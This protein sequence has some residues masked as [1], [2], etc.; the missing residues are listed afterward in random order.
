MDEP[1]KK[2]ITTKRPM[3]RPD[4]L[5][6]EIQAKVVMYLKRGNY[7][8]TAAALAGVSRNAIKEW[9]RRGNDPHA[10]KKYRDFLGAVDAA[11]AE[12]EDRDIGRIDQAAAGWREARD[13]KGNL[14]M[15][16]RAPNW[17]AAA[18]RLE[19][20]HPR[21]WANKERLELTGADGGPIKVDEKALDQKIERFAGLLGFVKKTEEG[22]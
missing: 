17:K 3:G 2:A 12:A 21:R 20:R 19:R 6:P 22:K 14:I 18:W 7:V 15:P 1:K 5:T 9:I 10:P 16:A 13:D 8:E 4:R 11:I